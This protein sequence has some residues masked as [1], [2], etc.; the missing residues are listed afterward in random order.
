MAKR[1]TSGNYK[2]GVYQGRRVVVLT[3]FW[4]HGFLEESDFREKGL[5]LFFHLFIHSL[6][7]SCMCPD[8]DQTHN[9][10]ILG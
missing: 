8:R 3:P 6:V 7:D 5:D 9:I 2:A 10:D 4:G 1:V